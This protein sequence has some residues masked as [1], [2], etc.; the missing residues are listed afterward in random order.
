M[1]IL[2]RLYFGLIAMGRND[3]VQLMEDVEEE[4]DWRA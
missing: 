4:G 2:L 1:T 3:R